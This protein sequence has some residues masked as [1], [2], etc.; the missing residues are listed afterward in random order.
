M[1]H[2]GAKSLLW[3]GITGDPEL[4]YLICFS[5]IFLVFWHLKLGMSLVFGEKKTSHV[6][7][8]AGLED[9]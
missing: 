6:V 2:D 9:L 8:R 7:G 5:L 1:G 3:T 4:A